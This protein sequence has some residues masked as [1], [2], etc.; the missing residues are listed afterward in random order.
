MSEPKRRL[1]E[2]IAEESY[3]EDLNEKT[4]GALRAMRDECKEAETEI[5]FERRLAQARIDILSA[6]L[7]RRAGGVDD[8][9]MSRL[10]QILA[11]EARAEGGQP[12]PSR[13]PDFSVPRNADIPRRRIEEIVG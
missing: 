6:E 13:A 11:T 2:K 3:L 12:L 9:L 1:V 7:D 5:S 10:P 8:D 4:L